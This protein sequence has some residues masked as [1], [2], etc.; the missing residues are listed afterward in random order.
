[1]EVF[2]VFVGVLF[3]GLGVVVFTGSI[4]WACRVT[5]EMFPL[6]ARYSEVVERS[7]PLRGRW[8]R[9]GLRV[10]L[11]PVIQ[12]FCWIIAGILFFGFAAALSGFARML[13]EHF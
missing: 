3:S 11:F 7:L 5:A 2:P 1:M 12:L 13:M 10:L 8:L 4:Y 9:I 6:D